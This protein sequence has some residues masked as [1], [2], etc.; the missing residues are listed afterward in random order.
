[1]FT[2]LLLFMGSSMLT[3]LTDVNRMLTFFVNFC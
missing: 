2:A 1:M 3:K